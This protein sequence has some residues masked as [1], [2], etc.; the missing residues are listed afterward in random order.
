MP[1]GRGVYVCMFVWVCTFAF[2]CC[3]GR[4]W[5]G[6]LWVQLCV[7][8]GPRD[9]TVFLCACV[10]VV[11]CLTPAVRV[12]TLYV[13]VCVCACCRLPN[14][15]G[16]QDHAARAFWKKY[17]W[18]HSNV[19]WDEFSKVCGGSVNGVA[20]TGTPHTHTLSSLTCAHKR[21]ERERV[22]LCGDGAC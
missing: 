14:S 11:G 6:C 9:H 18:G 4:A 13:C 8:F 22:N 3:A 21:D 17:F 20:H 19:E 7:S 2:L 15:F 12:T 16:L 5:R 10:R 1:I